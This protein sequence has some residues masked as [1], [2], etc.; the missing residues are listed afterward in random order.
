MPAP[1]E[2]ADLSTLFHR[3]NRCA[4]LVDMLSLP[5]EQGAVPLLSV[6]GAGISRSTERL[7]GLSRDLEW[8]DIET[9]IESEIIEN[10][11]GV[12]FVCCQTFITAVLSRYQG[13]SEH[14]SAA[15]KERE[16][17]LPT[18][19]G[20]RHIL[21]ICS[22]RLST[23]EPTHIAIINA[24]ANHFK[25]ASETGHWNPTKHKDTVTILR[26][27]GA[28]EGHSGNLS[29]GLDVL[30][31]GDYGALYPL[32]EAIGSWRK[33]LFLGSRAALNAADLL[34]GPNRCSV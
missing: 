34:K 18:K 30:G 26:A 12:A 8:A 4:M 1:K 20:T 6:I 24:L 11:A 21:D 32:S 16:V 10:L 29:L 22:P 28:R 9:D 23:T 15:H 17:D 5:C 7:Q 3:P 19:C 25:H 2:L 13:L 33:L 14:V 27:I 31:I